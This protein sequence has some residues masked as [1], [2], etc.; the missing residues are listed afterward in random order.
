[1]AV[2]ITDKRITVEMEVGGDHSLLI[3][4]V[5]ILSMQ[6]SQSLSLG[7]KFKKAGGTKMAA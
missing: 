7:D 3:S 1:M 5:H 2:E 4:W 6:L